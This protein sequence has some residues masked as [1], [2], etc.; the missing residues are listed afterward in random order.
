MKDKL[1]FTFGDDFGKLLMSIAQEKLMYSF[2]PDKATS[3][4]KD[5]LIGCT[6]ELALD[7]LIGK[8]VL[9]VN[10]DH[11]SVTAV[12]RTE[13]YSDYPQINPLKWVNEKRKELIKDG[14]ELADEQFNVMKDIVES[15]GKMHISLDV[16]DCIHMYGQDEN[17]QDVLEEIRNHSEISPIFG[18]LVI[19]KKFI[20]TCYSAL[21]TFRFLSVHYDHTIALDNTE[22]EEVLS[23]ITT[24]NTMLTSANLSTLTAAVTTGISEC[25]NLSK[26]I[27]SAIANDAILKKGIEPVNITDKYDAGWL[28]PNGDFYG[29][30]GEIA[31]ML[32]NQIADALE[33]IGIV[34]KD[35]ENNPDGWLMEHGWVRIHHDHILYDGYYQAAYGMD[36]I[37]LTEAQIKQLV[38]YGNMCYG[39]VLAF[40]LSYTRYAVGILES[41]DESVRARILD[42][43]SIK[44]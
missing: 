21:N 23:V 36:L 3:I 17:M 38:Q 28:S 22:L 18:L 26:Y 19:S 24:R 40:G 7:I 6:E 1:H 20:E 9:I 32:H 43:Q 4:I 35:N 34:P 15:G 8:K 14:W 37:P 31:N 44:G 13:E 29:L 16:L 39:G 27:E 12:D 10:D 41:C 33:E 30:N 2:E 25:G 5:S 42:Y 11:V